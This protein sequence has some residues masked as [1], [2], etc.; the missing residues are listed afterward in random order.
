MTSNI[1]ELP[2][3]RVSGDQDTAPS[4]ASGENLTA[5]ETLE[6]VRTFSQIKD[7]DQRRTAL[8]YLKNISTET[9]AG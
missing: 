8:D 2:V 1:I 4:D 7:P 5:T 3:G 9:V 6:L